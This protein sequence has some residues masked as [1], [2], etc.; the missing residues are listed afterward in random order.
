MLEYLY[1]LYNLCIWF[2]CFIL[3]YNGIKQTHP[4]YREILTKREK[5]RRNIIIFLFILFSLFT[6]Y[7]GDDERYAEF[8]AEGYKNVYSSMEYVY[9]LLAQLVSPY[10]ILWKACIYIPALL[11]MYGALRKFGVDSFITYMVFILLLL[12]SCGATRSVLPYFMFLYAIALYEDKRLI[13]RLMAYIIAFSSI[14]F[15][16]SMAVP[17]VFFIVSSLFSLSKTKIWILVLL[18]PLLLYGFNSVLD[19]LFELDFLVGT[20]AG[21]KVASYLDD[22][23]DEVVSHSMVY[24]FTTSMAYLLTLIIEF[25]AIK[26]YF[27]KVLS[28]GLQKVVVI[29][30]FTLLFSVLLMLSHLFN[31]EVF[32]TRYLGFVPFL[33]FVL[34][35]PIIQ[36]K[37]AP[38]W[39]QSA[40]IIVGFIK[41]SVTLL[42]RIYDLAVNI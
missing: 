12:Y 41:V 5:K 19:N 24:Y 18:L 20:H 35:L 30:I 4:R 9:V 23:R 31:S 26:A 38:R 3:A 33:T 2:L 13:I 34:V 10:Y 11:F 36:N 39:I 42:Y 32:V 29:S 25:Y 17:V 22:G 14:L 7:S 27:R 37:I 21:D 15:H 1:P 40:F 6:F 16:S 8:V 28:P